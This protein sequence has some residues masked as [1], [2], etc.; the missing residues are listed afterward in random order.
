[1]ASNSEPQEDVTAQMLQQLG[2]ASESGDR[3]SV[4]V[5]SDGRVVYA[6]SMCATLFDYDRDELVGKPATILIETPDDQLDSRVTLPDQDTRWQGDAI[7][8]K[9]SGQHFSLR[10]TTTIMTDEDGLRI[11]SMMVLAPC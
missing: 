2:S 5:A 8:V 11:G 3:A 1:L 7:G 10:L 6:N 4:I 9:K